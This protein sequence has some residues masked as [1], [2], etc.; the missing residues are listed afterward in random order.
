MSMLPTIDI[1]CTIK[2][3]PSKAVKLTVGIGVGR[4]ADAN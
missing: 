2:I 4:T 3:I 1:V